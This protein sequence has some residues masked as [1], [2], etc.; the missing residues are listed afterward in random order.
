MT[1]RRG[2]LHIGGHWYTPTA[3]DFLLELAVPRFLERLN[4][5]LAWH[6]TVS[7]DQSCPPRNFID[8]KRRHPVTERF[9]RVRPSAG[10][11]GL[12]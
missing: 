7:R 9:E 3:C 5:L 2:S 11:G 1:W 10:I 8:I 12:L 6:G 4:R